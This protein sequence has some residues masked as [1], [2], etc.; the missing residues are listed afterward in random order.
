MHEPLIPTPTG[1]VQSLTRW[2]LPSVKETTVDIDGV[3]CEALI[4][5]ANGYAYGLPDGFSTGAMMNLDL[6][7]NRAIVDFVE[8][9]GLPVSPYA[10]QTNHVEQRFKQND[11]ES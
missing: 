4:C 5:K 7:D 11:A 3:E 1:S 10:N 6:S 8:R 2:T 9:Y